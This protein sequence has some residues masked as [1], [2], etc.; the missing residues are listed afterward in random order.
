M[1]RNRYLVIISKWSVETNVDWCHWW[2]SRGTE[3]HRSTL[4]EEADI[5]K[6]IMYHA[7]RID[8]LTKSTMLEKVSYEQYLMFKK[9][10]NE[11]PAEEL[12]LLPY[13]HAGDHLHKSRFSFFLWFHPPE[14]K[15]E[16]IL[17]QMKSFLNAHCFPGR[18]EWRIPKTPSA[19]S[20]MN[21]ESFTWYETPSPKFFVSFQYKLW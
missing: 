14:V 5:F 8:L 20:L 19:G 6:N 18:N 7:R 9:Y 11:T 1:W 13:R 4:I 21:M 2:P 12:Q 10:H 15:M 17:R 3:G 16:F